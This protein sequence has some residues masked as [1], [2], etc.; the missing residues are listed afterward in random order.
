MIRTDLLRKRTPRLVRRLPLA[1][2]DLAR[3]AASVDVAMAQAVGVRTVRAEAGEAAGHCA[4]IA[5]AI[6]LPNAASS[7]PCSRPPRMYLIAEDR[8]TSASL[9]HSIISTSARAS[10]CPS[11]SR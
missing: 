4:R 3:D 2:L 6:F 10:K 5:A 9:P 1:L 7:S 11:R 8:A